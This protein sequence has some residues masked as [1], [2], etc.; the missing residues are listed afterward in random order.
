MMPAAAIRSWRCL[1]RSQSSGDRCQARESTSPAT[2]ASGHH[3]SGLPR[4]RS[5]SY[6]DGLNRGIGS[7]A[8]LITSRRS[9]SAVDLMPSAT[10]VRT[11]RNIAEPLTGP[12]LQLLGQ[13][14]DRAPAQLDRVRDHGPDVSQFGE[15]PDRVGHGAGRQRQPHRTGRR[16]P[17]RHP[18]RPVQPGEAGAEA[19]PAGR[20]QDVDDVH[21]G[22]APDAVVHQGRRAGDEAARPGVEQRRQ[23]L[24]RQA[25]HSAHGQVD[26]GQQRLPWAAAP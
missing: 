14:A 4:K 24:L 11:E 7:R 13:L 25:R 12:V 10:S 26:A 22:S 3:A 1:V 18:R 16:G 2:P 20:H 19:L 6:S 21:G 5:P 8:V 15:L 9:P 17:G 23:L